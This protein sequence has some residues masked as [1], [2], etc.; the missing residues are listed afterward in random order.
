MRNVFYDKKRRRIQLYSKIRDNADNK[1]EIQVYR[2][3]YCQRYI[4]RIQWSIHIT[5]SSA[6]IHSLYVDRKWRNRG[7]GT[8]L[9]HDAAQIM[10]KMEPNLLH[11]TL[12]D[13]SARAGTKSNIYV[14]CGFQCSDDAPTMIS[15]PT[16][17]ITQAKEQWD[18]KRRRIRKNRGLFFL[19]K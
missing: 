19:H 3:T 18:R 5:A 4:A 11:V 16:L 10:K 14:N 12:D 8:R 9:L 7:I 1:T 17:V 2:S 6:F 15:T 13:V